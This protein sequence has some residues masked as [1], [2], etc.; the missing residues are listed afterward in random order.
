MIKAGGCSACGT[1]VAW[2][3][4]CVGVWVCVREGE[5]GLSGSAPPGR[6][7]RASAA[8]LARPIAGRWMSSIIPK[9]DGIDIP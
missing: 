2:V 3:S 4:V 6:A 7:E 5:V 8:V 1:V 9:G